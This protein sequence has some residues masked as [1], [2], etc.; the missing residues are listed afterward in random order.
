[1]IEAIKNY[2]PD[3]KAVTYTVKRN[4]KMLSS[5]AT[6]AAV[7]SFAKEYRDTIVWKESRND[8]GNFS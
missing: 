8:R 2:T 4:N 3:T 6:K 7:V 5:E 1:M